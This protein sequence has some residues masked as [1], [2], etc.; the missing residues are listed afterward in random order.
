MLLV[1]LVLGSP[2]RSW[3]LDSMIIRMGLFLLKI[4]YDSV[5]LTINEATSSLLLI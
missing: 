2:E 3:E 5:I 1:S 4:L